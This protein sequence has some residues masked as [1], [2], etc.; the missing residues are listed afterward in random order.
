MTMLGDIEVLL[1]EDMLTD[2]ELTLR[3]LQKN[4]L[5]NKVLHLK[6][7]PAVLDFVFSTGPYANRK[8]ANPKLIILD[9]KLPKV[10]GIEVIRQIKSN[11]LTKSIPI[12]ALTSSKEPR[13]IEESYRLGVNSY[14]VK[15][16]DFDK[17]VK[18]ISALGIYWLSY[19][20]S[21]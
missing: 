17:F 4:N 13:D 21:A 14:I 19:N 7:G 16:V 1:G 20:Q 15:P 12:V 6:D 11:P 5:A 10:D 9:L 8:S 18:A 3:A 2:A